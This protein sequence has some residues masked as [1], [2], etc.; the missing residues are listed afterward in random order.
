M[1]AIDILQLLLNL[2]SFFLVVFSLDQHKNSFVYA[3]I[4]YFILFPFCEYFMIFLEFNLLISRVTRVFTFALY[5][6]L[7]SL[8]KFLILCIIMLPI[9]VPNGGSQDTIFIISFFLWIMI[10]IF[11]IVSL[12]LLCMLQTHYAK[13]KWKGCDSYILIIEIRQVELIKSLLHS[14]N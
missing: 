12:V 2:L 10:L 14:S 1:G 5:F 8:V 3:Y 11:N 6:T 7:F 4:P 13:V 9:T